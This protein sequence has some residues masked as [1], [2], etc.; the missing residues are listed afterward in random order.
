MLRRPPGVSKKGTRTR[1]EAEADGG[2]GKAEGSPRTR[3]RARR[4]GGFIRARTAGGRSRR[5]ACQRRSASLGCGC[6]LR[7]PTAPCPLGSGGRA[8]SAWWLRSRF[9]HL[10]GF[11]QRRVSDLARLSSCRCP[12]GTVARRA[13]GSRRLGKERGA[14]SGG[15]SP[16]NPS[17]HGPP[18][19][20]CR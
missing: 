11:H 8:S 2:A 7:G 15:A 1:A 16:A 5:R 18:L 17:V 10:D 12:L 14:S 3:P 13:D 20:C 9:T 19:G 4:Q 6:R